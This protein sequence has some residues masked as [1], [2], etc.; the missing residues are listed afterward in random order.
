VYREWTSSHQRQDPNEMSC[1][2]TQRESCPVLSL[3]PKLTVSRLGKR[4]FV[5][6]PSIGSCKYLFFF[7]VSA[8]HDERQ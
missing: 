2:S 4:D 6:L 3:L 8:E 1:D 5:H 7:S